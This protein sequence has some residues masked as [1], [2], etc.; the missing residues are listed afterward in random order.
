MLADKIHP[1]RASILFMGL[2]AIMG[3]VSSFFIHDTASY[4]VAFIAHGVLA[5]G[6]LTV[7]ASL[8]QRLLPRAQFAQY[9]SAGGLIS[10]IVMILLVPV[11]G[12]FLDWT[13]HQYQYTY[14]LGGLIALLSVVLGLVLYREFRKRNAESEDL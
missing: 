14:L 7:S 6:Y 10:S 4:G 8:F 2:Y 9:S 12:K 5:G 3:I 1:L 13:G 11:I